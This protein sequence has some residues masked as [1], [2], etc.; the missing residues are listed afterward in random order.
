MFSVIPRLISI[1]QRSVKRGRNWALLLASSRLWKTS[2]ENREEL[3]LSSLIYYSEDYL[4]WLLGD[5]KS[6]RIC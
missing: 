4:I 6:I 5:C 2:S 3:L 1:L